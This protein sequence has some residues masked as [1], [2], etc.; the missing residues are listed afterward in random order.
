M[1]SLT[2]QVSA[3]LDL[4]SCEQEPIRTPG[5]IQPHGFVL[6]LDPDG[7]VVQASDNLPRHLGKPPRRY[8][9]ARW[10]TPSA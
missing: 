1:T 4:S 7:R 8:W 6:A 10:R 9:A 2:P 3:T 5:S